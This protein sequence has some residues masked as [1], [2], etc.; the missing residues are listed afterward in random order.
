MNFSANDSCP[1]KIRMH[2]LNLVHNHSPDTHMTWH[3]SRQV[4]TF[5][6]FY[7]KI[8]AG[9]KNGCNKLGNVRIA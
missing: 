4:K 8:H 1:L 6:V 2:S 3:I 9:K 7:D 5:T